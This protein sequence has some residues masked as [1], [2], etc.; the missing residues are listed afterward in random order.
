MNRESSGGEVGSLALEQAHDVLSRKWSMTIIRTLL[1]TGPQSFSE[2]EETIPDISGKVLSDCLDG[3]QETEIVHRNV[4]QQQ[5][6]R[7]RYRLTDRGRDL[8]TAID[9]LEAWAGKHI[10]S[11][12][13]TVLV[14]DNDERL[15]EMHS[16]WLANSYEVLTAT[17]G[18]SARSQLKNGVDVLVTDIRM[19][20][21][22][23][24]RL[25]EYATTSNLGC[26]TIFLSSSKPDGS[27]LEIPFDAYIRKP[28]T[29][30]TLHDTVETV[31]E[32]REQPPKRREFESLKSR[33]ELVED[34]QKND[35]QAEQLQNR[36]LTL[37]E[38]LGV[39]PP[40]HLPPSIVHEQSNI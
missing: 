39:D 37:A 29:P 20:E 30:E 2:L 12:E 38:E 36:A 10:V 32:R 4:V 24:V 28:T 15:V 6:L 7:V 18:K 25:A 33:L 21:Q 31:L 27:I 26:G 3:L 19:P 35:T 23:G 17:H 40:A 5:P 16:T 9:A 8:E 22:S 11:E 14:V 1:R 34:R 13:P